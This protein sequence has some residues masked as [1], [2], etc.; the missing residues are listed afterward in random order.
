MS[1]V[2]QAYVSKLSDIRK[3]VLAKVLAEYLSS[4]LLRQHSPTLYSP[5]R[6]KAMDYGPCFWSFSSNYIRHQIWLFQPY[7]KSIT[8]S[9]QHWEADGKN[10][11]IAVGFLLNLN[12]AINK[13]ETL[14]Q[15]EVVSFSRSPKQHGQFRQSLKT[16]A[17]WPR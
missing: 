11:T 6:M 1:Q 13:N 16:W 8:V 3:N 17:V 10:F 9:L 12:T 2:I 7:I 15:T 14:S 5:A 4:K